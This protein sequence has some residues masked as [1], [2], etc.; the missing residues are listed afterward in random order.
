LLS[1]FFGLLSST[2]TA[3]PVWRAGIWR[4]NQRFLFVSIMR[5]TRLLRLLGPLSLVPTGV[6]IRAQDLGKY[7]QNTEGAFVLYDLKNDCY[8]RSQ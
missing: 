2:K 7:F 5:N 6:G 8:L 3:R 1:R 4:I